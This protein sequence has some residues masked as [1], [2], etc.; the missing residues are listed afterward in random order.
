MHGP[1]AA[2]TLVQ[3]SKSRCG[4]K[5]WASPFLARPRAWQVLDALIGLTMLGISA[6]LAQRL[7][8]SLNP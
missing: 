2:G 3:T 5:P 4:S 6:L 7:L 8:V 1:Q